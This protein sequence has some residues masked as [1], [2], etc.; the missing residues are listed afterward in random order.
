VHAGDELRPFLARLLG[1]SDERAV[2]LA[3][4][5]LTLSLEYRA[6]LVLCGSGDLVP[7]AWALHR[8]ALGVYRL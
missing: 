7:I 1:W 2:E 3:L 8:R 6:T 5:S 4:R